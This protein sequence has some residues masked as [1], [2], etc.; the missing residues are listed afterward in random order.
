MATGAIA[1]LLALGLVSCGDDEGQTTSEETRLELVIGDQVPLSGER[2]ALGLAGTKATNLA[3]DRINSAVND[4]GAD[5][6]VEIVHQDEGADPDAAVRSA[7]KMVDSDGANCIT[8]AW[9]SPDAVAVAESIAIPERIPL[10]SSASTADEITALDDDGLVARTAPPERHQAEALAKAIDADIGA[11]GSSVNVAVTDDAYG[12]DFAKDFREQ[13]ESLGG[14]VGADARYDPAAAADADKAAEITEGAPD[15]WVIIGS[16]DA[17]AGL[18]PILLS[19]GAWEPDRTW[20][21]EELGL[22]ARQLGSPS[23]DPRLVEGMRVIVP[24]APLDSEASQAFAE[25]YANADPKTIPLEAFGPQSFD[26]VILCYLAAVA[27]KSTDGGEMADALID[28]TAPG[29]EVYSWQQLPD[30]IRALQRDED[31]D[32][33]GASGA[34]DLDV[35]GDPR[36]ASYDVA[37]LQGGSLATVDQVSI[38]QGPP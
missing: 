29:G 14:A 34:I 32:Y 8:G 12:R 3:I 21:T 11:A 37:V 30:A 9:S 2:A 27:A 13:W 17:F 33:E 35:D 1:L 15:A 10:I 25:L 38:A 26:A 36:A 6:V 5:H 18:G 24:G 4:V 23:L 7:R 28:M 22:P 20:T 31:I 16:P 19:S